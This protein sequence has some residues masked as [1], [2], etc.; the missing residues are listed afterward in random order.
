MTGGIKNRVECHT[1]LCCMVAG[2][3]ELA[4]G[5]TIAYTT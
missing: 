5:E 4:V 1:L 3:P 2:K